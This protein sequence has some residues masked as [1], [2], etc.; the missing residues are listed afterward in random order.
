MICSATFTA[1]YAARPAPDG[2]WAVELTP[3]RG[4]AGYES[5]TL[6]IDRG[7]LDIVG[8]ATRDF[9]GGVSAYVF[10]NV[11]QNQGLSDTLFVF[12]VPADVE[13]ITDDTFAR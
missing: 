10:S 13:V 1:R 5:L 8:M 3:V 11:M 2:A 7:T 9:Q 6:T 12:D 4:G